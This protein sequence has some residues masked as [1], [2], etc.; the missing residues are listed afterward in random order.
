MKVTKIKG[1]K[2]FS[3][4]LSFR[5]TVANLLLSDARICQPPGMPKNTMNNE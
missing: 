1:F 5:L 4:N 3:M 2:V